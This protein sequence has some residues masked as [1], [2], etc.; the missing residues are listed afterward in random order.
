MV[1][2]GHIVP[3]VGDGTFEEDLRKASIQ[4]A[5]VFMAL[6]DSETRNALAA[7]IARHVFQVPTSICRIDDPSKERVYNG[8]GILA[9]SAITLMTKEVVGAA[10]A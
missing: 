1:E 5:Q 8:L 7:Q 6:S 4:D 3:L 9:V 10:T 2:D